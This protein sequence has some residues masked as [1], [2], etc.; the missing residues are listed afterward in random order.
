LIGIILT[1]LL[2]NGLD[3]PLVVLLLCGPEEV[4]VELG[5]L[6]EDRPFP[7]VLLVVLRHL[8]DGVDHPHYEGG[9]VSFFR[10][11]YLAIVVAVIIVISQCEVVADLDA[12][13]VDE[14]IL[15]IVDTI[16]FVDDIAHAERSSRGRGHGVQVG[17][18]AEGVSED[19][20]Q[21][22]DEDS[23]LSLLD[24]VLSLGVVLEG[25][26]GALVGGVQVEGDVLHRVL[27]GLLL[28][29]LS[30]AE[31][32]EG[33]GDDV[34]GDLHQEPLELLSDGFVQLASQ[35]WTI[36]RPLAIFR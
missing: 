14:V 18:V 15:L 3:F 26:D 9:V 2:F 24:S 23:P 21:L 28:L 17:Q 29:E 20:V 32:S 16:D 30:P 31:E 25:A 13:A 11:L 33:G 36:R 12:I 4:L 19:C 5:E 7:L 8:D 6:L 35:E 1:A 10:K 22:G 34:A 27:L